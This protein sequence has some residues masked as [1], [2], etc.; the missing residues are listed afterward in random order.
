[1]KSQ[2]QYKRILLLL[3]ML[4][5]ATFANAQNDTKD[6]QVSG[7]VPDDIS[8]I[9]IY[10][11]NGLSSPEML[12]SVAI[13]DGRF[14]MSGTRP[15]YDLL[16]LGTK[17]INSIQFFNDGEPLTMDFVNDSLSASPLNEKFCRYCKEN[18]RFTDEFYRLFMASRQTKDEAKIKELEQQIAANQ[19]ANDEFARAIIRD[20]RNNVIAAYY[21]EAVNSQSPIA[22]AS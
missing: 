9:Y 3:A 21:L 18:K 8:K 2:K 16:S 14:T 4:S 7:I 5:A 13:T 17:G 12:D 15:A 10:K 6:Y 20:N 22:D 1:M 19:E 11:S